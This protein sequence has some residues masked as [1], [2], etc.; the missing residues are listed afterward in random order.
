MSKTGHSSTVGVECRIRLDY[1]VKRKAEVV[2]MAI[3]Q[4]NPPYARAELEGSSV[5]IHATAIS[6][7]SMLHTLED[8]LACVKVAE[9]IFEGTA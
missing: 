9:G 3:E 5:I 4:D 1:P 6:E 7:N 2:L 8:L